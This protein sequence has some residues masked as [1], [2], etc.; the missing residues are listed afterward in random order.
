MSTHLRHYRFEWSQMHLYFKAL[1]NI[2]LLPFCAFNIRSW[3]W[4][5]RVF[6]PE[7]VQLV[8]FVFFYAACSFIS[9][10]KRKISRDL[11]L[12]RR[13]TLAKTDADKVP[14]WPDLV[15]NWFS[16]L[17]VEKQRHNQRLEERSWFRW[18]QDGIIE[19]LADQWQNPPSIR[20][21]FMP[22]SKSLHITHGLDPHAGW[23]SKGFTHSYP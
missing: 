15:D 20:S 14:P 5:S 18:Q 21:Y 13:P 8:W 7:Y 1:I 3:P 11:V 12:S 17:K 22:P 19:Y 6:R 16:H 9:Q 23:K 10:Q 2:V 4:D